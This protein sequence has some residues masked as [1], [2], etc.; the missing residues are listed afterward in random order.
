MTPLIIP[1]LWPKVN[2]F[3]LN[4]VPHKSVPTPLPLATDLRSSDGSDTWLVVTLSRIGRTTFPAV[5]YQSTVYPWRKEYALLWNAVQHLAMTNSLPNVSNIILT[6]ICIC[7]RPVWRES[8]PRVSF[9]LLFI[10]PVIKVLATKRFPRSIQANSSAKMCPIRP[11]DDAAFLSA[12]L[13]DETSLLSSSV[14]CVWRRPPEAAASRT[15]DG[16]FEAGQHPRECVYGSWPRRTSSPSIASRRPSFCRP[17]SPRS[18]VRANGGTPPR[19]RRVAKDAWSP[20]EPVCRRG[21]RESP[22][23]P[24]GRGP[25]ALG[26]VG[27]SRGMGPFP[28]LGRSFRYRWWLEREKI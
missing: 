23:A 6:P 9:F 16:R 22:S 8:G 13:R 4:C 1:T 28:R 26:M 5:Y 24:R 27:R 20:P 2:S 11:G 14:F 19:P 18:R 3:H 15:A 10:E 17:R 25:C 12:C 21:T 7:E